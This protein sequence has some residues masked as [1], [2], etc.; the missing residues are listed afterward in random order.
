MGKRIKILAFAL[1]ASALLLCGFVY[2]I[3]HVMTIEDHYGDLQNFYFRSKNGDLI[4]NLDSKKYGLI[5]KDSKRI[6]V[7]CKNHP[8]IDLYKWVYVYED[9]RESKNEVYRSDTIPDL[10][11]LTYEEV[12]KLV[13][14]NK[15]ELIIKN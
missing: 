14:E 6:Q 2:Q 7:V 4:L 5:R 11:G 1:T 13:R 3:A 12:V 8:G 15:M 9:F 10:S